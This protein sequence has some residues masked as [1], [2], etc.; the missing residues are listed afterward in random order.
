MRRRILAP[1]LTIACAA[2]ATGIARAATITVTTT[3]DVVAVDGAVSFREAYNSINAGASANAD[4][5]PA[6][7][8]GVSDTIAFNITG[9]CAVPCKI[10]ASTFYAVMSKPIVIDGYTQPGSSANTLAVG[11]NAVIKIE[12]DGNSLGFSLFFFQGAGTTVRG[13]NIHGVTGGA[14][15]VFLASAGG[16]VVQ[17]CFIGTN[18]AGTAAA[19]PTGVA[20]SVSG[21]NAVIGGP[22]PANRNVISGTSLGIDIANQSSGIVIQ[23]NYIGTNAAGTGAIPN[24]VGI[25]GTST[26]GSTVGAVLIGGPSAGQGNVI[27]GNAGDGIFIE[28]LGGTTIGLVTIQGNFI[29]TDAAGTLALGNGG[30]GI[31]FV[32]FAATPTVAGALV[33]G[34]AAGNA[35]VIAFNAIDGVLVNGF[36][37]VGIEGNSIHDNGFQGIALAGGGTPL[38]NDACDADTGSNNLQNYPV[39]TAASIAGSNV[40]ISGT[41][42]STASTAFRIEFFSNTACDASGFGEGRTFLGFTVVATDASCNATFGPLVFAVPAGQ[43]VFTSTATGSPINTSQFSACF[44]AGGILPSPTPT[45]TR[46][47]TPIVTGTPIPPT[48][49]P[50]GPPAPTGTPFPGAPPT[51]VP[52]LSEGALALF[53]IGLAALA[54]LLIRRR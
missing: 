45:P 23:G 41:L 11:D 46:T 10:T 6:G 31:N 40:T 39:L 9:G 1:L 22:L 35:N 16:S 29:G 17:G 25:S 24:N 42:N 50:T 20:V 7:A 28:V 37:N 32:N 18:P 47:V 19:A 21:V 15:I 5:V 38:L 34:P 48:V 12:I 51:A 27:S 2:A 54:L 30:G 3:S 49:T 14:A 43:T 8:Y 33:G 13:L 36:T 52:T 26:G 53:G 4:V 44:V